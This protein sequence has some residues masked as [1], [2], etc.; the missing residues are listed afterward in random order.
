MATEG[1]MVREGGNFITATDLS[2]KQYYAVKM[3]TTARTVALASTGGEMILGILQ[4]APVSPEAADVCLFG[5]TKAVAGGTITAGDPL[6]TDTAGKLI[7]YTSSKVKVGVALT[8]A[9]SGDIFSAFIFPA[10]VS[11]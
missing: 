1:T 5:V 4:N 11:A 7:T 10:Q 6:T 2:A 9:V 3:T 8:S